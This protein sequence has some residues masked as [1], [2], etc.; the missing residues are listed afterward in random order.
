M[1]SDKWVKAYRK[2]TGFDYPMQNPEFLNKSVMNSAKR[3]I[4]KSKENQEYV[5][6]GYE[7]KVLGYLDKCKRVVSYEVVTG[8][9]DLLVVRYKKEDGRRCVYHP[10]IG[11]RLKDGRHLLIEVKSQYT[12]HKE[13]DTNILKFKASSKFCKNRTG[14]WQFWL[15]VLDETTKELSWTSGDGIWHTNPFGP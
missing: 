2:K 3:K 8:T 5:C 9:K 10:D 4:F 15:V 11:V 6:Q 13:F 1:Q 12:L 14:S 7:P